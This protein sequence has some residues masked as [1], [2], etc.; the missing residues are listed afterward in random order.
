MVKLTG[1]PEQLPGIEGVTVIVA[2]RGPEVEFSGMNEAMSPVPLAA[3]PMEGFEFTQLKTVPGTGP[4][5]EITGVAVLL[6]KRWSGTAFAEGTAVTVTVTVL[7]LKQ[8][9]ADTVS[10]K[11]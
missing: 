4:E 1:I 2:V 7:L 5:K 3:S 10:V 6:Q 11:V 8:P 9:V